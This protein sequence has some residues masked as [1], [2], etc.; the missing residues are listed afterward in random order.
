MLRKK[1]H[2]SDI[3]RYTFQ[4]LH[5]RVKIRSLL[6]NNKYII[7]SYV[8]TML[9]M[10]CGSAR[11]PSSEEESQWLVGNGGGPA[12]SSGGAVSATGER[13]LTIRGGLYTEEMTTQPTNANA[14]GVNAASADSAE[15][16]LIDST[17]DA[18][19]LAQ[20]HEEAISQVS[21]PFPV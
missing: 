18:T 8:G 9:Q 17:A 6:I 16:D 11:S 4:V 15:H 1:Y 20:F 13:S 14:A 3:L 21:L 19:L 5:D 10:V 12:S 7:S 2:I